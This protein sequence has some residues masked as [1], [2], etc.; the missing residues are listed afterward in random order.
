MGITI[1]GIISGQITV[2]KSFTAPVAN[3]TA[4]VTS[5]LSPLTVNF[6]DTSTNSPTSWLWDFKNDGTA[7]STQ[8][9][10]SYT[11][12][13]SG[14]YTVKLTATNAGGSDTV[15]K[16]SY[17]TVTALI[18]YGNYTTLLLDG[19][20]TNNAQNNTFIDSSSNNFTITRAGNATQGSFT[21]F[22]HSN[23]YWSTYLDGAG[24]YVA[25]NYSS[26][27]TIAGNFTWETWVYDIGTTAYATILGWRSGTTGWS[28]FIVQRNNG[29]N[30]LSVTINNG[31]AT[32]TQTSGTYTKNAWNHVA[33]TR[34]GTTVTLWVNGVSAGTGTVSGSFNPG[35]SYWTGSDNNNNFPAQ[36][37]N[38]YISNQR[39]VNGTALY[40][41]TFTPSTT[42]L[43][44]VANTG[45]LICQSNILVDNSTNNFALSTAGTPTVSLFQPFG[46][47]NE[48]NSSTMG[49][50]MYL[51]GSGDYVT[52]PNNTALDLGSSTFTVE[53]WVYVTGDFAANKDGI[54][55]GA[56]SAYGT[57]TANQGWAFSIDQTNNYIV[58]GTAG[59]GSVFRCTTPI[60][61]NTWYHI[62]AVKN[63]ATKSIYVNGVSQTIGA[64]TYT[65]VSSSG[66]NLR[67]GTERLFTDYNH[68]FLGYISNFRIVKG[69]AVYTSNFSV[70]TAPVA[71]I[72]NTSILVN[73]TNAAIYDSFSFND[74]E[75]LG[76]AKIS[77]TQSKWGGSSM[78][79]D[80]TGDA[81]SA[82]NSPNMQLGT[83]DFT[84]ESWIYTSSVSASSKMILAKDSN[85]NVNY[86]NLAFQ[87]NGTGKLNFFCNPNSGNTTGRVSLTSTSNVNTGAWVHTAITRSGNTWRLFVNGTQEATTTSSVGFWVG[88]TPMYVGCYLISSS[89][90]GF[91]VGYLQGVRVTK[92]IARYTANFT[93]PTNY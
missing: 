86:G 50:S 56:I 62:A 68:D 75:T 79:F 48:Y 70:P 63:G 27:S 81:L 1:N 87:V 5:G 80:G 60:R 31:A 44:A 4:N 15:T 52:A 74:L 19:L 10:P 25:A 6:T 77:T 9:N 67:I 93:P 65:G 8:Q 22:S 90:G 72:T 20:G 43:T 32:I 46:I 30:N 89:P 17:I 11:Y 12:S 61:K 84:I 58:F 2:S 88:T 40:T 47:S 21:P 59:S 3:F 85:E 28:G 23:G 18:E 41:S 69:T 71:N 64:D 54:K 45:L 35:T 51:D 57:S 13:E 24:S 33:L 78:Y 26:G 42:P 29:A 36:Q 91:F 76:D 7:T 53:A 83:G 92:G 39:F 49:G 16:I 14:T 34:S 66:G 37:L 38:G 82:A 73:S 55:V